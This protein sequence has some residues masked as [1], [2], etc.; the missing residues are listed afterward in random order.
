MVKKVLSIISAAVAAI[1][2][3]LFLFGPAIECDKFNDGSSTGL[4]LI[5]G[6]GATDK[7]IACLFTAI[8]AVIGIIFILLNGF[9]DNK[10][11]GLLA[12]VAF[13]AVFILY[14]NTPKF[15]AKVV[16]SDMLQLGWFSMVVIATGKGAAIA[17]YSTILVI[18]LS[19]IATFKKA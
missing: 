7:V 1:G 8:V 3:A 12:I 6:K 9:K 17:M 19:I 4:E 13:V 10:A 18:V 16:E 14:R 15:V 5:T 2:L 11:F